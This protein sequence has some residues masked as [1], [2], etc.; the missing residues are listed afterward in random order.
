MKQPIPSCL[1]C[2][3]VAREGVLLAGE[4]IG[5]DL[6]KEHMIEFMAK[7]KDGPEHRRGLIELALN[8][9]KGKCQMLSRL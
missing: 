9:R 3:Q 4:K 6:C 8:R 5:L 2:D 1:K 7:E